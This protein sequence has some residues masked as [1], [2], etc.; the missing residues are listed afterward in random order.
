MMMMMMMIIMIITIKE[1]KSY[2]KICWYCFNYYFSTAFKQQRMILQSV[3]EI[4][5]SLTWLLNLVG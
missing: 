4:W 3:P 5:T 1:K 2:A